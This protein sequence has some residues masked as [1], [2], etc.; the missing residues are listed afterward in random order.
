[1]TIKEIKDWTFFT[2]SK[3]QLEEIRNAKNGVVFLD[4]HIDYGEWTFFPDKDL[5]TIDTTT[6]IAYFICEVHPYINVIN[7]WMQTSQPV[8]IKCNLIGLEDSN[9][10]RLNHGN[11]DGYFYYMSTNPNWKIPGA[12]YSLRPYPNILEHRYDNIRQTLLK[13]N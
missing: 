5:S 6:L 3:D 12:V 11:F 1:M 9:H 2:G 4:K 10:F 8:Y 7:M 13:G